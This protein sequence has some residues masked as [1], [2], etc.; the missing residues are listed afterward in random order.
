LLFTGQMNETINLSQKKNEMVHTLFL[1]RCFN[2]QFKT[3]W[4]V[5]DRPGS[6]ISDVFY[7]NMH[8]FERRPVYLNLE[9]EFCKN[10][11]HEI[12]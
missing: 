3:S 12:L 4:I 6:C 11:L 2:E 10:L 9:I 1:T 5:L 7:Y 8:V